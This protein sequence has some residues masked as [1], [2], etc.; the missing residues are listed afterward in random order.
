MK[1]TY[2]RYEKETLRMCS[3]DI[4]TVVGM[5]KDERVARE[6]EPVREQLNRSFLIQSG[7]I[8]GKLPVL[9]FGS[10]CRRWE[11]QL[12]WKRY[13]G[14]VLLE[15]NG[16]ADKVE[17]A[18]VRAEAAVLPQTLLAFVGV[19]GRSVKIVV[20]FTLPNGTL[21]ETDAKIK[22]F[23]AAAYQLAV[24]HFQP[25][26]RSM[27]SLKE[28][29]LLRG[30]RLSYDPD[31]YYNPNAV[32][33]RLEQPSQMP[34]AGDLRIIQEAP[35]DPLDRLMP[36]LSRTNQVATLYSMV[37]YDM[38]QTFSK[39]EKDD[40]QLLFIE[41]GQTCCRLGIPEEEAVSWTLRYEALKKL[42]MN[43]RLTFRTAYKLGEMP[44]K[45]NP[46]LGIPSVMTLVL[47]LDEFMRRRY[48]FRYNEMSG[49]VEYVDRSTLQFAY[50]PYTQKVRNSICLEAQ[51]EGLNVWDKDIDRYVNSDRISRYHPIGDFLSNLPAWDRKAHIRAL[52]ARVPCSHS[53]WSDLFYRWFLSMVAHW[54][55]LDREHGN[56]T[57]PLLVGDQGCGKSTF[58]LNLLPPVLRPYYTDSIDF[59][60]RRNAEL[61]LH[62]YALINID[63]FD[64]VK[65]SHQSFLKHVL[66]KAVVN[67]RL[68]YQSANRNLRRYA[69]FIATSNNFDLLTDPSGSR[70]FICVEIDGLIDY[71]QPIDYEQLYAE[72]KE[73]VL[74]GERF[75][76]THEEEAVISQNNESFQ[77]VP[78]EEQ[79]FLRYFTVPKELESVK[80]LL[81]S[82]ILDMIAAKQP[83]FHVTKT[84]ILNFGKLLK[85]NKVPN[86]R[87]MRGTC[88]FVEEV[89]S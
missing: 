11:G 40:I 56:S 31:L 52:A 50:Q 86:K 9:V 32:P 54:M 53:A 38:V 47:Q 80:P 21:P 46:S 49:E 28:P 74:A 58:C 37:L 44:G 13:S 71:L 8:V 75:W 7:P 1:I 82:E 63:E 2:Y 10:T 55:E 64:A 62:R 79:L 66:Q 85:R 42:E 23:H 39:H 73:Q 89:S 29:L 27:I 4:A 57:T 87:T 5:L 14:Y 65:S 83:G 3:R 77:Q 6:V 43:I 17:A 25:Q 41:L 18:A 20:P 30:C 16:L 33:I 84:M 26:L 78:A 45:S 76:F 59:G 60:N 24:R 22:M 36:G 35:A 34:D 81:A 88:Y 70:R 15:V 68:P 51:Q 12:R 48:Y 69:T 67:T 72:A 19:S 61:A